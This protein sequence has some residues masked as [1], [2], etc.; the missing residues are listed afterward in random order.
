MG[1]LGSYTKV[2][3]KNST[4]PGSPIFSSEGTAGDKIA[5]L[6]GYDPKSDAI[7]KAI[8][9]A[10]SAAEVNTD[11]IANAQMSELEYKTLMEKLNQAL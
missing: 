10:I 8:L 11:S 2:F 1:L 4:L 7:C 3:Y 9:R 5:N 6:E